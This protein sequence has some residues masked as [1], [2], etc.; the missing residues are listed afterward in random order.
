MVLL[1]VDPVMLS[2][3]SSPCAAGVPPCC[4]AAHAHVPP[5]AGVPCVGVLGLVCGVYIAM[6]A[7]AGFGTLTAPWCPR[8][9]G[10]PLRRAQLH[11][12]LA[13]A[14]PVEEAPLDKDA[15]G[16]RRQGHWYG[17]S[18]RGTRPMPRLSLRS[19]CP[20]RTS[21]SVWD[22]T[23]HSCEA[24]GWSFGMITSRQERALHWALGWSA[25]PCPIVPLA[26]ACR[27]L[28]LPSPFGERWEKPSA[29]RS[30]CSSPSA[31]RCS[32]S[33]TTPR[34]GWSRSWR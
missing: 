14:I 21:S 1:V 27:A 2:L 11:L 30:G 28:T 9:R 3:N 25:V 34:R 5:G 20:W 32:A 26:T 19:P 22:A 23:Y 18:S 24:A 10:A 8:Q 29:S 31:G 13:V 15:K 17:H 7:A 6:A 12:S 16:D 33:S 4:T